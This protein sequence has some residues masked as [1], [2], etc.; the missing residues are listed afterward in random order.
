MKKARKAIGDMWERYNKYGATQEQLAGL[1]G[2]PRTVVAQF[3][4]ARNRNDAWKKY[5]M[6]LYFKGY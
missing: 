2:I 5:K 3:V 1:Y 4:N 6:T